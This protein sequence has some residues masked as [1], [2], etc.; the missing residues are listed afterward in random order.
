MDELMKVVDYDM[1]NLTDS[2]PEEMQE[3]ITMA[4]IS[5]LEDHEIPDIK[6]TDKV[7]EEDDLEDLKINGGFF[8]N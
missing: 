1:E 8:P 3:L 2:T 4:V 6:W 5:S 7:I